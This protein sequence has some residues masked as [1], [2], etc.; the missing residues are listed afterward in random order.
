[1]RTTF[2]IFT[3]KQVVRSE[4]LMSYKGAFIVERNV[5]CLHFEAHT[6]F[7]TRETH[8]GMRLKVTSRGGGGE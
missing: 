5:T 1:M 8:N 3:F 6:L 2:V 7:I 4:D